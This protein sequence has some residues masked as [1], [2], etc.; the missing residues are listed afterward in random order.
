M[1]FDYNFN[2]VGKLENDSVQVHSPSGDGN[3][4]RRASVIEFMPWLCFHSVHREYE[5]VTEPLSRVL[6]TKARC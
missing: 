4:I 5:Q 1:I 3:E 6:V 2:N